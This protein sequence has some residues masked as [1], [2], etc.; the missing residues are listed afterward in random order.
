MRG[1]DLEADS[2]Q[3][4]RSRGGRLVK[5][6]VLGG[7]VALLVSRELR[8]RLLDALFGA[9]EEFDYTSL[10]EPATPASR[11]DDRPPTAAW[12]Q[13]TDA[14][15]EPEPE[16][17]PELESEREG[18]VAEPEL[19]IDAGMDSEVAF[20]RSV[21]GEFGGPTGDAVREQSAPPRLTS[22]I[23]PS[24]AAWRAAAAEP[25]NDQPASGEASAPSARAREHGSTL[26]PP[27]P[28]PGWWSP[29]KPGVDPV[30]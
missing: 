7:G 18:L 9:E 17:E 10:T 27:A 12:V 23:A 26:A 20:E 3:S 2:G 28:P 13:P 30:G 25:V 11:P 8:S 21:E 14:E 19:E 22:S 5:V 15:P 16:P 6:A 24:P 1:A 4:R 29:S